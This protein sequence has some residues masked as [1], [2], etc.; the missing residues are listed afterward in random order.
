MKR[1][2]ENNNVANLSIEQEIATIFNYLSAAI[3]YG[4]VA[5]KEKA[6]KGGCCKGIISVYSK[7]ELVRQRNEEAEYRES[8]N[9]AFSR[10]TLEKPFKAMPEIRYPFYPSTY[11]DRR[12]GSVAIYGKEA[13]GNYLS[14]S[15]REHLFGYR[16]IEARIEQGK[17]PFVDVKLAA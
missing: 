12:L 15:R 9:R 11:D 14:I 3:S 17:R 10:A 13:T 2:V 16:V 7:R 5:V 4:C 8:L 1:N 6:V